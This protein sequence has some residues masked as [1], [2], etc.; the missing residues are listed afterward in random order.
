MCKIDKKYRNLNGKIYINSNFEHL[1]ASNFAKSLFPLDV[2][3][4]QIFPKISE[5]KVLFLEQQIS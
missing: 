2:Y 3:F 1:L 4:S 5:K